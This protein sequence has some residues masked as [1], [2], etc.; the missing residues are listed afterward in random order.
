MS[1][2]TRRAAQLPEWRRWTMDSIEPG[3][4]LLDTAGLT[5]VGELEQIQ[6]QARR[7]GHAEGFSAGR[8]QGTA[9]GAAEAGRMR[10][11][12]VALEQSCAALQNDIADDVLSLALGIARQVLQEALPVKR[13][14]LLPVVR[15]AIQSMPSGAQGAQVLLNPADVEL[16]R[17]Y[18]G[19]ELRLNGWQIVEDHRVQPGGCRMTSP[20]CEVDAT[21]AGRWKRVL[22]TLGRDHAWLEV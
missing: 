7:E 9:A 2:H 22:A 16:V 10:A 18:F 15:E 5:T 1:E 14:L 20:Y 13:E 4:K 17:A 3:R 21:L 6:E 19:E 8:A 11:L 12:L